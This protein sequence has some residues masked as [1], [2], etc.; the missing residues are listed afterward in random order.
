MK[1][2]KITVPK[3]VLVVMIV[4]V[5]LFIQFLLTKTIGEPYPAII[6]PGFGNTF[7]DIDKVDV[8]KYETLIKFSNSQ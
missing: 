4:T 1:F 5:F 3:N 8:V 7:R 6:F 2:K